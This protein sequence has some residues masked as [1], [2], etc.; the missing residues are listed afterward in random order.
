MLNPVFSIGHLREM[1]AYLHFSTASLLRPSVLQY[2]FST[3]SLVKFA[4]FKDIQFAADTLTYLTVTGCDCKQSQ[5]RTSRGMQFSCLLV[6][7][8][9]APHTDW[10]IILDDTNCF[11]TDWPKWLWLFIWQPRGGFCS[12]SLCRLRQKIQ[13]SS[14]KRSLPT[15]Y[16]L[17]LMHLQPHKL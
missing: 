3:M 2:R 10:N 16:F 17:L 9:S 5:G 6:M 13:V 7:P 14:D 1:S 4:S 12:V 15:T 11:G 8:R